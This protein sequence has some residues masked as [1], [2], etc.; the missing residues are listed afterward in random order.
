MTELTQEEKKVVQKVVDGMAECGLFCGRYDA[1]N[2]SAEFM[3]GIATVMEYLAYL[4]SDDYGAEFV[5]IFFKNMKKSL[6]K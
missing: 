4:V 2:G 3:H 1:K 5:D 6:D